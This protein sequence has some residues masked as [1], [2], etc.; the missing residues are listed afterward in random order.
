MGATHLSQRGAVHARYD[1]SW[2]GYRVHALHGRPSIP[3]SACH[4]PGNVL[5]LAHGRPGLGSARLESAPV[6]PA[7]IGHGP[8]RRKMVCRGP[9]PSHLVLCLC[10]GCQNRRGTLADRMEDP[11]WRTQRKV[12]R[13]W[14]LVVLG[15]RR[16]QAAHPLGLLHHGSLCRVATWPAARAVCHGKCRGPCRAS[17]ARALCCGPPDTKGPD[18]RGSPSHGLCLGRGCRR[19]ILGP[20]HGLYLENPRSRSRRV[21]HWARL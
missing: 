2:P 19:A 6:G 1:P 3:G 20:F 21:G 10:P 16:R 14:N 12:G 15:Q 18:G 8:G 7:R 17:P 13:P 4:Y 9:D 5:H 11:S